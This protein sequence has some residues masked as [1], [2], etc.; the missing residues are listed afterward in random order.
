MKAVILVGGMGTRLRPLTNKL[1]KSMVPVTGRPAIEHT[2]LYLRQYGITD[3]ILTLSYLPEAISN[4]LG[5]GHHL[6]VNL[7][8]CLEK[9]PL[10]TAG[11]V[12]N[13]ETFLDGNPILVLNG[14][15]FTDLNLNEMLAFH[16]KNTASA[17]ISLTWVEDPSSFGVV[18]MMDN[19]RVKAFIEKPPK[20]KAT[21][22][23]INAGTYIL[24]PEVLDRIQKDQYYMFERG[25][26]PEM[27]QAGIP[28]YGYPYTGY[29]LDMGTPSRYYQL[30]KD[31]LEGRYKSPAFNYMEKSIADN[32]VI[33]SSAKI[34]KHVVIQEN[35]RICRN[36][37][38]E[39]PTV[40]GHG[41]RIEEGASITG[42][43]IWDDVLIH[44]N[45]TVNRCVIATGTEIS[46]DSLYNSYIITPEEYINLTGA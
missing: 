22:N 8:Y 18:E 32:A 6:G 27:L 28:V 41:C 40:I 34:N 2:L 4:A 12:K 20:E 15:I 7:V 1:P 36:V 5:D 38:I 16:Q 44:R 19:H 9:E 33:D 25:L 45:A 13:T 39:G 43:I 3:I 14:D 30:N 17:T 37:T 23:W 35:T 10:G 26:F 46:A 31:I 24:Q 11:A 21:T 29:W 42:S